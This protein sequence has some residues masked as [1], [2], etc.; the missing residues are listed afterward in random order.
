MATV[1]LRYDVN[2][3]RQ[4]LGAMVARVQAVPLLEDGTL[5]M[6]GM[7]KA[8]DVSAVNGSSVRRTITL[9]VDAAGQQRFPTDDDK[10][11]AT[12]G[13]CKSTLELKLGATVQEQTP[14][15]T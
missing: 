14:V 7:T 6:L 8:I 1:T 12:R 2:V 3:G 9:T 10:I 4:D 5:D 13:L 15:V 11:A